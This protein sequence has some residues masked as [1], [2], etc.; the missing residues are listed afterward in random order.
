MKTQEEKMQCECEKIYDD[1][2]G[3]FRKKRISFQT[4]M[5]I[6]RLVELETNL[7][8]LRVIEETHRRRH[9][10]DGALS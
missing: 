6:L 5:K 8:N 3:M 10:D 1:F 4:M 2:K 7:T 9:R